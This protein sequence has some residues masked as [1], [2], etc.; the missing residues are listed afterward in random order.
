MV[1]VSLEEIQQ[2]REALLED[3][4]LN[5]NYMVLTVSA[6]L[7]ASFG[8]LTNSAAVIIGAM[9]IAPLMMPL[10]ALAFGALEGNP[11]LF[12]RSLI[13][14]FIAT[15]VGILLS[16]LLGLIVDL[17]EFG[18][19]VLA[20]TQP[21]LIDLGIAVVAGGMSG[22]AKTRPQVSDALAGTA[23]AVALMPPLCVVGLSFSQGFWE[24]S[25]GALLLYLTNLLGITLACMLV[26]IWAGYAEKVKSQQ[27][28][29]SALVLTGVLVIPL[30]IS[31]IQ[32]VRQSQLQATLKK[33]LVSRT[34]TVGQQV[35][36]V[37]TDVD[38]TANPPIVRLVVLANKPLT[39]KQVDLVEKFIEK[40]MKKPFRLVFQ[41][42]EV[43]EVRSKNFSAPP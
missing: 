36:L 41:V 28:L 31:F 38:W 17:P 30:G 10:R 34:V 18:S 42:R 37:R 5:L 24:F 1:K 21:N 8:L 12:R 33:I 22:F 14:L 25:W 43:R 4:Q 35:E 20:R 2:I 32:L 19:E 6:C 13:S 39:S 40:E 27:A 15:M 9:I 16:C 11:I 23:I 26:F 3:A 29:F 7:I